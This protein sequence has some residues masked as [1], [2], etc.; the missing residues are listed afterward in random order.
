M[1][2]NDEQ[3]L[4]KWEGLWWKD[5]KCEVRVELNDRVLLTVSHQAFYVKHR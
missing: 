2:E 1:Y 3:K 4:I 5:F